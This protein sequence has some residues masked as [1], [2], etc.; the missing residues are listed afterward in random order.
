MSN[1]KNGFDEFD[2]DLE[3]FG[4]SQE[5]IP[6]DVVAPE[7]TVADNGFLPWHKPR[8]QWVRDKQWWS[9]IS[10]HIL[11]H[12][13]GIDTVRYFG[14]PGDDILDVR[15]L[16]QKLS[17]AGKS[18][19]MLG[20][21]SS[22][23]SWESAQKQLSKAL[24]SAGIH[25]DSAIEQLNFD[26]LDDA[27][28]LVY[29]KMERVGYFDV[30][31]LDFCDNVIAP[32]LKSRRLTAIKNL[33]GYQFQVVPRRWLLFLTTRSSKNSSCL[34]TFEML[35]ECLE[36]NLEVEDFWEEFQVR[37]ESAPLSDR[38][39]DREALEGQHFINAYTVGI[40]KY[41]VREAVENG[42]KIKMDSV[43]RYSIEGEDA[44][45]DMI[46]MCLVF[47]K[48]IKAPGVVSEPPLSEPVAAL[49]GLKKLSE[50]R[51]VDE[52]IIEDSEK[53]AA[54]VKQKM[55]LLERS[56]RNVD[57][58]IESVCASD[59]AAMHITVEDLKSMIQA[60]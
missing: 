18:V 58:Y 46:S 36:Q 2:L 19:F 21:L 1:M 45:P 32:Q 39:L 5:E 47:T 59:I 6:A 33:L 49:R 60:L 29:R 41:L 37:F 26:H 15:Y 42:Y 31:N 7:E 24:D 28:S 14:L 27:R 9:Q 8:K 44:G 34:E 23:K 25:R 11:P 56:G 3:D 55:G 22:P 54:C 10:S 53:Y 20:L 50:M 12:L 57:N 17:D 51:S 4:L 52:I 35:A 13:T 38:A 30:V 40:F 16:Q 48:V 43:V